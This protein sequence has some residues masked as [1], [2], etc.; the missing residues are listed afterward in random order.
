MHDSSAIIVRRASQHTDHF[1]HLLIG[2]QTLVN[3]L[4]VVIAFELKLR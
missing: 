2:C 3:Y 1:V 4:F